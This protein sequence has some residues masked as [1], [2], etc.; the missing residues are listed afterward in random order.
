MAPRRATRN[1][2]MVT[3]TTLWNQHQNEF[4]VFEIDENSM[5]NV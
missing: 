2:D 5:A 1:N 3:V 4:T